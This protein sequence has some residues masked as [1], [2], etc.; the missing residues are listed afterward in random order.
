MTDTLTLAR[1][2]VYWLETYVKPTA[3]PSGYA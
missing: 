1:W 2:L 3:K